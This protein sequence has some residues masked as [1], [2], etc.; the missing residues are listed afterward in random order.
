MTVLHIALNLVEIEYYKP[1]SKNSLLREKLALESFAGLPS[2]EY[3]FRS[4]KSS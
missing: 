4:T 1:S 2:H 3:I